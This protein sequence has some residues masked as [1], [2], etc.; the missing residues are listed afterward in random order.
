MKAINID[1]YNIIEELFA[2]NRDK[3]DNKYLSKSICG[4]GLNILKILNKKRRFRLSQIVFQ[5]SLAKFFEERW[6]LK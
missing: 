4:K 5:I 3:Q 6:R 1:V 2:F